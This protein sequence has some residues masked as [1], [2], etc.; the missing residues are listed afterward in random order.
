MRK[1]KKKPSLCTTFLLDPISTSVPPPPPAPPSLTAR[2]PPPTLR[3]PQ[4]RP[5]PSPIDAPP[6]PVS[7]LRRLNPAVESVPLAVANDRID[8]D[9]FPPQTAAMTEGAAQLLT[10]G[11]AGLPLLG[12]SPSPVSGRA[13]AWRPL[14]AAA[15]AGVL[16]G[17]EDWGPSGG[18]RVTLLLRACWGWPGSEPPSMD[19]LQVGYM[20]LRIWYYPHLPL[21][22]S[23]GVDART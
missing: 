22:L 11:V 1:E 15:G 16:H 8:R 9:R 20:L 10:D 6:S 21:S 12:A 18:A 13:S 3:P 4:P 7:M 5:H 2:R 17:R 14:G 19:F 23:L